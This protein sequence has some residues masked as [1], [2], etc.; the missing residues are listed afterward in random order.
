M[1]R[2][3]AAAI[4]MSV[5]IGP[6]APG[7]SL[8]VPPQQGEAVGL[9]N[10]DLEGDFA[11]WETWSVVQ[12]S[13][14]D[15]QAPTISANTYQGDDP[16]HVYNSHQSV[17]IS[18]DGAKSYWAGLKQTV[19]NSN[20]GAGVRLRFTAYAVMDANPGSDP[21]PSNLAGGAN[22]QVGIDPTGGASPSAGAVVWSASENRFDS[23]YEMSVEVVAQAKSIT[24]FISAHPTACQ[25]DNNV[26]FDSTSLTAIGVGPTS[27]P[28]TPATATSPPATA[29]APPTTAPTPTSPPPTAPRK[30]I[31]PTPG[32]DGSIIYVV[33]PGDTLLAIAIAA[34]TTVEALRDLN[35]LANTNIF[36][37]QRLILGAA[38]GPAPTTAAM[39][40]PASEAPT[41]SA[42]VAP[43]AS[44]IADASPG[45][46]TGKVCVIMYADANGDG[47]KGS[48]ESLLAEGTFRV[49]AS[50]NGALVGEYK[51][52]G[53]SEPHCFEG[54]A[55]GAYQV[56]AASPPGY[57]L[58]TT[59]KT[60][61]YVLAQTAVGLEF[62]ARAGVSPLV[63][64]GIVVLLIAAGAA[65]Y[66]FVTRRRRQA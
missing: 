51:T 44:P 60:G 59:A 10:T 62:G 38:G 34:G 63:I 22:M 20:I 45:A 27:T 12:G 18:I 33:Q 32:S 47:V 1:M 42:S 36:A 14:C 17:K 53:I 35:H 55:P 58:T 65:G 54:L 15:Y 2:R 8:G 9:Q 46:Q 48:S 30:I 11:P 3:L 5:L 56:E 26:Y 29:T 19:S 66:F 43:T 37:G 50:T 4:V 39:T 6:G 57:S 7:A 16:F 61:A 31:T 52:D 23:W 41:S 64:A 24:V 13:G 21:T 40:A 28:V 25:N 49:L